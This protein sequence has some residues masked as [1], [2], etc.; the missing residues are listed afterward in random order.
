MKKLLFKA[1]R[2]VMNLGAGL[3]DM[4][5]IHRYN[6]DPTDVDQNTDP[7]KLIVEAADYEVGT[8]LEEKHYIINRL[9]RLY[10]GPI[11][12]AVLTIKHIN[13][14]NNKLITCCVVTPD[15]CIPLEDIDEE[16]G[17]ITINQIQVFADFNSQEF[18]SPFKKIEI[19]FESLG[20]H[21]L[22]NY[23]PPK[24]I[25]ASINEPMTVDDRLSMPHDINYVYPK[26]NNS[27]NVIRV[28]KD[29]N[30]KNKFEVSEMHVLIKFKNGIQTLGTVLYYTNPFMVIFL[31]VLHDYTMKTLTTSNYEKILGTSNLQDLC[32]IQVFDIK[33]CENDQKLVLNSIFNIDENLF[34]EF[35]EFAEKCSN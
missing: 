18:P 17:A 10:N 6:P 35:F 14:Y 3:F 11:M 8:E 16:T 21:Q 34:L 19:D 22:D 32:P 30:L 2:V 28:L 13:E 4:N 7:N 5:K 25:T 23:L 26:I 1:L 31:N 27:D 29:V 24:L 20:S 33:Y 9:I 15:G 12:P